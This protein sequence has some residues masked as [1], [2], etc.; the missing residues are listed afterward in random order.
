MIFGDYFF[1]KDFLKI[2]DRQ[3]RLYKNY[4]EIAKANPQ[5][6][7]N[8]INITEN[9]PM[10]PKATV[11]AAAELGEDPNSDRLNE[12]NSQLY[13]QFSKKEAE[14]WEFM[15][16]K[17]QNTEYVD[18]MRF[19]AA[20][21]IKGDT[22]YGVWIGAAMDHVAETISKYS[23]FPNTGF[24][25]DGFQIEVQDKNGDM[26]T[27]PNPDA[28]MAG[29]VWQYMS[30]VLAYDKMLRD[31][32]DPTTAI[33]VP[34]IDVSKTQIANLGIDTDWS[35][36][37]DK[38]VDAFKEAKDMGGQT[39][40]QAMRMKTANNEPIN[41]N[42]DRWFVFET[43]DATK[44]PQYNDLVNIYGYTP[45]KAKELIHKKI[46]EP[47]APLDVPG[48]INY[49][50]L[51]KPNKIN[52]FA[53]RRNKGFVYSA[54]DP[55]RTQEGYQ[56]TIP[57]SPGRY[58]AAF[59]SA[60]GTD[61]YNKLSGAIDL[62]YKLVPELLADK[63]IN[64][65]MNQF[66]NLRRV[67]KLLDQETGEVLATGKRFKLNQQG[68]RK[69]AEEQIAKDIEGLSGEGL[70]DY[71]LGANAK[72]KAIDNGAARVTKAT[73]RQVKQYG[74]FGERVPKFFRQTKD[75]FLDT[76]FMN[77]LFYSLADETDEMVIKANPFFR[78]LDGRF[79]GKIVSEKNPAEIKNLFGSL[80]DE[81]VSIG[82]YTS[83]GFAQIDTMPKVASFA[84]N[85]ALV[86]TA[87]TGKNLQKS[88]N[89]GK[90]IAGRALSAIGNE[91]AAFRSARS[92]LGQGLNI[93]M[94]PL[95]N[96]PNK[97]FLSVL[98]PLSRNDGIIDGTIAASRWLPKKEQLIE[99]ALNAKS[100][101]EELTNITSK[102]YEKMLGFS[103][104]FNAGS[105]P[106]QQRMLGLIPEMG[107]PL[108]NFS[109]AYDQLFAH[110]QSTGYDSA[111]GS[112]ILEEFRGLKYQ[113][114]R[115]VRKFAYEQRVR[116]IQHVRAKGGNHEIM[117]E[118][119]E[120][121]SKSEED[122]FIMFINEFGDDMPFA[123]NMSEGLEKMTYKN[124]DGTDREI[125]IPSAHLMSEMADN[126]VQLTDY[127]LMKRSMSS[128]FTYYDDMTSLTQTFTIPIKN[129]KDY[130]TKYK[131]GFSKEYIENPFLDYTT[132]QLKGIPIDKLG[133]DAV[134]LTLDYYN[135][136]VFKPAVLLRYAFFS[137]VF[138][139][140]SMRFAAGHM[141]SF[142][143]HPIHYIQWVTMGG[144]G[145]IAKLV[146]GGASSIDENK[147]LDSFEHLKAMNQTFSIAGL[148]GRATIKNKNVKYVMRTKTEMEKGVKTNAD[149]Y[150]EAVRFELMLLRSD[151]IARKVA[152]YGYGSDK[153]SKW[154]LSKDG[155]RAREE[156]VDMGGGRFSKILNDS[157]FIDQYL[158]SV[159]ARIRIKTGGRVEKGTEYFYDEATKAYKYNISATDTGNS[160]LRNAIATGSLHKWDDAARTGES[161]S[162]LEDLNKRIP[163]RIS[164]RGKTTMSDINQELKK[165]VGEKGLNLDLGA[166]KVSED[167][168]N[169]K[170]LG[171]LGNFEKTMDNL[172]D[173]AFNH[174][175]G[176]P[177]A[178]LSRSV[179]FKQFRYMHIVDNFENYSWKVR[180]EFIR[181]AELLKIPKNVIADLKDARRA[182]PSGKIDNFKVADT[183]A[184][185]FGLSGTKQL[186][187]DTSKRHALSDVTRNIFPFPEVWF[188]LAST[189][190][191]LL[192][193]NPQLIR[194]GQLFVNGARGS[195][196]FGFQNESFFTPDP[197][198]PDN[199]LFA[200]PFSGFM[201]SLIYGKDRNTEVAAKSY[202]T[203]INLLGQGFVPGPNPYVAFA[204]DK[205]LPK[206]GYGREV[207]ET[208]FGE[209]GTPEIRDV[210]LPK[211]PWLK[212]ALAAMGGIG[213]DVED[214]GNEIYTSEYAAMRASTTIDIYR[215][216]MLTGENQRLYKAGKLDKFLSKKYGENF[217][218]NLITKSDI[219]EAFLEYSNKKATQVFAIRF[220][221]QFIG[222]TGI[223]P[224]FYAED[225]DGKFFTTQV[226]A[227][228]YRKIREEV[229]QDDVQAAERFFK[230]FGYD[231][232]WLTSGKS[233]SIAGR[234]SITD[235]V[236]TWQAENEK[237]LEPYTL[238]A[239]F[240]LPDNPLD[241]RSFA[242][243]YD[244][245]IMLNP[246]Q[247]RRSVNDT[248]AYYK[249]A[250]FS[251]KVESNETIPNDEKVF[252]KRLVRNSLI[253]DYP[254]FQS[255]TYG[256]T[257]AVK[258]KDIF[259]EM[260]REWLKEGSFASTTDAGKGFAKLY[261]IWQA[262][263]NQSMK[264]SSSQN[265][266][267]WLSSTQDEARYMRIMTHQVAMQIAKE[268]PDFYYVWIGVMLR[269]YRDDTEALEYGATLG[270]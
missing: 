20:N 226:L 68:L 220:L 12:I 201:G 153:L 71:M 95:R 188:E 257:T 268:N 144:E 112:K 54:D 129:A 161:L 110:L 103:S 224:V 211:A 116:D 33:N 145:K 93:A 174:M 207:R 193:N 74:F 120:N 186:L 175:M 219:D 237:N 60:P 150:V 52:F 251:E 39:I 235:R 167:I 34:R 194:K 99:A 55:S 228:E 181:E 223:K 9:N 1:E 244:E 132:G 81:G 100:N 159:E 61:S 248:V 15:N 50:S 134:T 239:Y 76:P 142:F 30:S 229:N 17:Y 138:L 18:D 222:P 25:K 21:W 114:H 26:V 82:K 56:Q 87:K 270:R 265:P 217:N 27:V 164:L 140:E 205:V 183:N 238:S 250:A 178:Y 141:D 14:I 6:A 204:L 85:K 147:L 232:G 256:I 89:V 199:E 171:P 42:R 143:T 62:T 231:H 176:K 225:K 206:Y 135:R 212:K 115:T 3:N 66:K 83:K 148:Q 213:K 105:T 111:V 58:Q 59:V 258:A 92:Y 106:S 53:G 236:K 22:Q 218:K 75:E 31:G 267:W 209:F 91:Q 131:F 195:N 240:L 216:G 32:V 170:N 196:L 125:I 107:L 266:D 90:Q 28:P 151:E 78:N 36:R 84:L 77:Q 172:V 210:L 190:S 133:Q 156:L 117:A 23:P 269:L 127:N 70:K 11:K 160:N 233:V 136:N 260:E 130:I 102:K 24:Y 10:L 184:K 119:L 243:L 104:T 45:E 214:Y 163:E 177:N 79:V 261:P 19:T 254:G 152:E 121:Y 263:G 51:D 192:A 139:E 108:R 241:D 200:H 128:L 4:Q 182:T 41:Y 47:I 179:A 157:D 48:E 63:G 123:G 252:L 122:R 126:S 168:V 57:Y 64:Q 2:K 118:A 86:S 46:G 242:D 155:A 109:Q 246:D 162:F 80:L 101:V 165:Y 255:Q 43:I 7:E 187:Y 146:R 113:D 65:V 249:Y 5:L 197:Q 73:D 69:E 8:V 98:K 234:R 166:V 247:Y 191:K 259:A 173:I 227:E 262:M 198:N 35:G 180:D 169:R 215:Y 124:W 29:R 72:L 189:W 245:S 97:K 94:S 96:T 253:I 49:L 264:Y 230:E 13:E 44:M 202:V 37:I 203:G 158:Q 154:I 16:E 208:L 38:L 149:D 221:A 88:T 40:Y 67:N 185:A 137:R